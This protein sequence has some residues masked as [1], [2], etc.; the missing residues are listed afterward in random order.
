MALRDQKKGKKQGPPK[1]RESGPRL[2]IE[3]IIHTK[4]LAESGIEQEA[5]S[6]SGSGV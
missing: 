5:F 4:C 3:F 6:F 2:T 1:N